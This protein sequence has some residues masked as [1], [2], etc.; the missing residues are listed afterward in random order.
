MASVPASTTVSGPRSSADTKARII[1]I[2][3][4]IFAS[5]GYSHAGL[6]EIA[7]AAQVAPSLVIKYFGT[8]AKLFEEALTAAILPIQ[9]FQQD[10]ARIGEAIVAAILDSG[11]G[12]HSPA[13]IALAVGDPES[14]AITERVVRD[15]IVDPMAR[16]LGTKHARAVAL[17][18]VA[19]ATGFAIFLRNMDHSLTPD[20]RDVAARIFAQSLQ[21]MVDFT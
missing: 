1:L 2:A 21:N 3:Q 16:W 11:S 8:K 6:R 18:I 7:A 17:N 12:M 9:T 20:E 19:G 15:Q 4:E 5:K 14:R 10:R 13:M